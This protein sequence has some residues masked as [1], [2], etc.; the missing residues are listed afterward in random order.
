MKLFVG[1]LSFNAHED[2]LEAFFV[3]AGF[4]PDKVSIPI[5]RDSGKARGFAFVEIKDKVLAEQAIEA[6]SGKPFMGRD[7]NVNE[8]RERSKD[9]G[10]R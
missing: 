9:G 7:L 2:D 10:R 3:D 4:T 1:N 5:D 6:L 8:A